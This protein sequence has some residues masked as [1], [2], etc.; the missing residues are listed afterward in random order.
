MISALDTLT[1]AQHGVIATRPASSPLIDMPRSGFPI[2]I[3]DAAVA[4]SIA[5][6]P[7]VFVVISICAI[8]PGSAAI[9]EPD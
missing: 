9:V 6:I 5:T 1:N 8:A 7:A 4:V 2:M 3:Q